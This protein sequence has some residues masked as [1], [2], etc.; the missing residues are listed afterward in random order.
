MIGSDVSITNRE[1]S[2]YR[3][4]YAIEKVSVTTEEGPLDLV[5]K[6][7]P[8][9]PGQR[10]GHLR[11][12]AY[13]GDVYQHL[14]PSPHLATPPCYGTFGLDEEAVCLVLGE[15]PGYRVH[16]STYPRGLVWACRDL[17]RFHR[18]TTHGLP[19]RHNVFNPAHLT[20]VVKDLSQTSMVPSRF[21]SS[22][23]TVIATLARARTSVVHGELYPQNV[24]V[25]ETGPVV[26][27]WESAGLGPGVLDLAVLTQGSWDPDLV[28]ECEDVY[29]QQRA[30]ADHE[31]ARRDLA[32]ARV[33]AA[34][35]LLVH[36]RDKETD[37]TQQEIAIESINTNLEALSR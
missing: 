28:A 24:I 4:T 12:P 35:Q 14:F 16:H 19:K 21:L 1:L 5:C 29:W 23:A 30:E 33:W 26:I 11:G 37:G 13:E 34:G 10:G 8:A 17:A 36:L 2:R 20:E 27:D 18:W 15:V 7:G 6:Y 25:N 31:L 22:M 9:N 3:S 32:A